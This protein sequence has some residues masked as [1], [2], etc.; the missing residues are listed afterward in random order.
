MLYLYIG[1]ASVR[2]VYFLP[3]PLFT[4]AA[5]FLGFAVEK[6]GAKALSKIPTE[7][8]AFLKQL[9][10]AE[11]FSF[12]HTKE[13]GFQ[14]ISLMKGEK[15]FGNIKFKEFGEG[16][17]VTGIYSEVQGYG[18][19]LRM[20]AGRVAKAQGKKF[21]I[22]DV[23]G[24]MSADEMASWQRLK[25]MGQPV[26][27]TNVPYAELGLNRE[28]SKFAYKWDLLQQAS[29]PTADTAKTM[30]AAMLA[31]DTAVSHTVMQAGAGNDATSQ[32]NRYM[33]ASGS[34]KMSAAL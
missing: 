33:R 8:A 13:S 18:T 5:K 1:R 29:Q 20:E 4:Q 7:A 23:Y 17:T 15:K 19:K 3:M 6:E 34:R 11:G 14:Q 27:E 10:R 21:V 26:M 16:I 32:A 9:E 12:V 25:K 2:P 24:S 30:K 28:G 31:R 22:S